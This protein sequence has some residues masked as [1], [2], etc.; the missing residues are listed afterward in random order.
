MARRKFT[1]E[2]KQSA[3]ALIVEQNYSISQAAE[4]LG[5]PKMTLTYWVRRHEKRGGAISAVE[6]KDLR[7]RVAELERENQRLKVERE[8]LKKA[9]AFFAKEQP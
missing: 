5:V 4:S 8:I 6:E 7:K 2:F 9:T 1:A 3:V